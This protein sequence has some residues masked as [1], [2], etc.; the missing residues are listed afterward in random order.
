MIIN[1]KVHQHYVPQFYLKKFAR[2]TKPRKY[3]INC[4]DKTTGKNFTSSIKDIAMEKYFYDYQEPQIVE[5]I[6]A[7]LE[8]NS[9]IIL[10][11]II[12]EE[13][14]ENL[15]DTE[16]T[17]FSLFI[18]FQYSRTRSAR[19]FFSQVAK[20]IYKHFEEDKNYPKINNFDPQILKKFVEDRGFTA[21]INIM[22]GPKEE[23]EIL[24]ITEETSKLIFNL[25]WN[26]TKNDFKREFYTGD[27][28]VII[29]NPYSD[30]KMIKGYGIQAFKSQG[31]EIFFPLT[32]KLCLI[33]YDKRVSEYK[34]VSS[35]RGVK[36]EELD[37]IN[38]QIIAESYRLIFTKRN[39]F[40]FVK[41]VLR[42]YPELKNINRNRI[43]IMDKK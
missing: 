18:F 19:E 6:F 24:T 4:F 35:V 2:N 41:Q 28:P 33:I 16:R 42:E 43:Y 8:S 5:T 37:W 11:K 22:F 15:T 14:I 10:D 25:D 30:E 27:H 21:Q 9:S 34:N 20:L 1:L 7:Y 23:N 13:S 17:I 29:Y 3:I 32:P 31:V 12:A 38:T 36:K 26:I 39:D 40:Q